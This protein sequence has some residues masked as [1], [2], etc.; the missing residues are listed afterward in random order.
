MALIDDDVR[1]VIL[2]VVSEEERR[3]ATRSVDTERLIGGHVHAC[4][5]GVVPSVSLFVHL[6]GIVPEERLH[7][8]EPLRPQFVAV[9]EK[10][11]ALQLSGVGDSLQEIAGDEGLARSRSEREQCP[12]R[13]ARHLALSHTFQH[14]PDG[15][16]LEVPALPFAAGIAGEQWLGGRCVEREPHDALVSRAQIRRRWELGDGPRHSRHAGGAIELDELMPVGR[17]HEQDV[18]PAGSEVALPL[19]EPM[20]RRQGVF[21]GFDE[22]HCDRL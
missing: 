7:S 19:V 18:V 9:A 8:L 6:R 22:G 20:A 10:Q 15:R 14:G 11:G 4:V 3:I 5:L 21:L 12:G 13:P 2:G 1:E 16:I 17:E